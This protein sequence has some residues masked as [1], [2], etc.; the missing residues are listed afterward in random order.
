MTSIVFFRARFEPM[1]YFLRDQE[2]NERCFSQAPANRKSF[3][4]HLHTETI[5]E[6]YIKDS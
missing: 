2:H 5:E 1:G 3:H 6:L 4:A